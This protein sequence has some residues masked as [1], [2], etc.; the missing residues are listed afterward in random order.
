MNEGA[1]QFEH[2]SDR[3]SVEIARRERQMITL[4]A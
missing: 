3:A 4:N 1:L 2:G